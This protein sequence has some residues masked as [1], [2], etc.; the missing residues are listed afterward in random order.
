MK[1]LEHKPYEERLRTSRTY[2]GEKEIKAVHNS[3]F[4]IFERTLYK[5]EELLFSPAVVLHSLL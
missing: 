4:Y 3:G 5:E 1:G 2:F